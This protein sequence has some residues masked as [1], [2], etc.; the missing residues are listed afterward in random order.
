MLLTVKTLSS[1]SPSFSFSGCGKTNSIVFYDK[2]KQTLIRQT[3]VYQF[4]RPYRGL[5][6][7]AAH[8]HFVVEKNRGCFWD[9]LLQYRQL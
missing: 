2:F 8:S 6:L 1:F 5:Q 4:R 7:R 3:L 9:E